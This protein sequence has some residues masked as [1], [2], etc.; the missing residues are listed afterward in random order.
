M[1]LH[2]K[3]TCNSAVVYSCKVSFGIT[4]YLTV[5]LDLAKYNNC[6]LIITTVLFA[7]RSQSFAALQGDNVNW[8]IGIDLS[9][10]HNYAHMFRIQFKCKLSFSTVLY[11]YWTRLSKI[12]WFVSGEQINYL[13]C[14]RH[15]DNLVA[16]AFCLHSWRLAKM[17]LWS[18]N[19]F[20]NPMQWSVHNSLIILQYNLVKQL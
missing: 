3:L 11:N 2:V 8:I 4:I 1:I 6:N 19:Q 15:A 17:A 5:Y 16:K 7:L 14:R 12:S 9:Y 10:W 20:Y 18:A 13:R